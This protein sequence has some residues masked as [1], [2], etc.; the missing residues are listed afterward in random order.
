MAEETYTLTDADI[1][2][3]QKQLKR[4]EEDKN[5]HT[6]QLHNLDLWIS[7]GL[8][9]QYKKNLRDMRGQRRTSFEEL[10]LIGIKITQI[11]DALRQKVIKKRDLEEEQNGK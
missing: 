2:T 10:K 11:Y 4:L 6:W 7:K 8:E 3:L 1:K 9:L 5:Y